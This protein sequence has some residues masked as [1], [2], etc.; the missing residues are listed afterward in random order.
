MDSGKLNVRLLRRSVEDKIG[1]AGKR[2]FQFLFVDLN[3]NL[4][5]FSTYEG[6]ATPFVK[7]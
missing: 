3:R 5:M 6:P 2:A 1:E 4:Q 7:G